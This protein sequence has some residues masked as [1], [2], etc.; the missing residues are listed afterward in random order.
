MA[1]CEVKHAWQ[2]NRNLA[3]NSSRGAHLIHS[4]G[5]TGIPNVPQSISENIIFPL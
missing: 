4:H 3:G 5:P 1:A 2:V